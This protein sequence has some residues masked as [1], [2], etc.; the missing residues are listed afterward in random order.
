MFLFEI[1]SAAFVDHTKKITIKNSILQK[2][3][4]LLIRKIRLKLR[5]N[6][7]RD[8][9]EFESK[10]NLKKQFSKVSAFS[11]LFS[12]QPSLSRSQECMYGVKVKLE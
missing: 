7:R 9:F 11:L 2:K 3:H 12:G 1:L 6:V 4:M 5:V 8:S 10:Q